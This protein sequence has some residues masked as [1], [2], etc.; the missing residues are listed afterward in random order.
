MCRNL[1]N[2]LLALGCNGGLAG[3][4]SSP[5]VHFYT[6]HAVRPGSAETGAAGSPVRITVVHIPASLDCDEI[7]RRITPDTVAFSDQHRWAAP[8]DQ[9]IQRVLTEDLMQRLPAERVL[10]PQSPLPPHAT[11]IV[12]DLVRFDRD[13][14]GVVELDGRWSLLRA[15]TGKLLQSRPLH[16]HVRSD[17]ED[18]ASQTEAMSTALGRVADVIASALDGSRH[19]DGDRS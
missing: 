3:C 6:L 12:I 17:G 4:A 19:A 9:I 1:L 11:E 18:Y 13:P 8:L 10:A 14:S 5:P 16:L 7:A 2:A 15:G